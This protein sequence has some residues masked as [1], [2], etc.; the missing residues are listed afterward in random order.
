[1]QCPKAYGTG[2]TATPRATNRMNAQVAANGARRADN[3]TM[4]QNRGPGATRTTAGSSTKC[5]QDKVV[6][7]TQ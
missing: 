2:Q 5:L 4:K 1:M 7:L 3:I 6:T